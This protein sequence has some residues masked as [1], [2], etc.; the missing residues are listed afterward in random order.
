MWRNADAWELPNNIKI[1]SV[2]KVRVDELREC[3]Q[4]FGPDHSVFP[5]AF[6]K[7]KS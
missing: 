1:A 7:Y 5:F 4:L 6:E 2:G 3:L